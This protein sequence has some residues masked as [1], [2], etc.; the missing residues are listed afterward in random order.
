[1]EI[2]LGHN[3][4]FGINHKAENIQRNQ[5][6]SSKKISNLLKFSA[7]VGY[8]GFMVS[9]HPLA[10]NKY[11]KYLANDKTLFNKK[12]HI[13]LLVPYAYKINQELN[14]FGPTKLFFN[15]I[16]NRNFFNFIFQLFTFRKKFFDT[17][18]SILIEDDIKNFPRNKI[19]ALYLHE[20]ITDILIALNQKQ[21]IFSFINFCKKEGFESGIATRNF[22]KLKEF[23]NSND[24]KPDRIL[25]H[26]NILGLNMNPS[27]KLV[28]N[29]LKKI[30]DI[31][32]IAMGV[33]ASGL[34]YNEKKI[35]NYLKKFKSVKG[36]IIGTTNK[37]QIKKNLIFKMI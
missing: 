2:I 1:M 8:D 19:V 24:L 5:K 23:L 12:K 22:V 17:L 21:I 30:K 9:T 11:G 20:I 37:T 15:K 16:L 6:Y 31:K 13:H 18:I 28:E 26:L 7:Q 25:T 4:F 10:K 33:F 35:F 3:K 34:C 27:K 36:L 32:I 29:N 14:K